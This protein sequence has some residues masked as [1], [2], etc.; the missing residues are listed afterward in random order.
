M[1]LSGKG[2]QMDTIEFLTVCMNLDFNIKAALTIA[3]IARALG[4]PLSVEL[5]AKINDN[6]DYRAMIV[7]ISDND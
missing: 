6:P 1:K 2:K 7:G 5:I 3:R 4:L